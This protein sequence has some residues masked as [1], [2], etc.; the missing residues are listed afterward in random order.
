MRTENLA[1][2]FT[3]IKGYT[4]RTGKQTH[5]ETRVLLKLHANLVVPVIHGFDGRV[6]KA[7]G[8][9]FLVVFRSPTAAVLCGMTIQDVLHRHNHGRPPEQQIHLRV[10][11]NVGEVLVSRGDV[12]G[13]PVNIASRVEHITPANEVYLT[14]A[15]HLAM[16]KSEI[17]AESMGSF[18]LK[19]IRDAVK[20]FRVPPFASARKDG[21]VPEESQPGLGLP[22]RELSVPGVLMLPYGGTHLARL[23]AQVITPARRRLL[24]GGGA[25][26][27]MLLTLLLTLPPWIREREWNQLEALIGRG[28]TAQ[29][30]RALSNLEHSGESERVR[31]LNLQHH[32]GVRLVERDEGEPAVGLLAVMEPQ[33]PDE[34]SEFMKLQ[35]NIFEL[36]LRQGNTDSATRL[37]ELAA[38]RTTPDDKMLV[39]ER[40]QLAQALLQR[41]RLQ[42]LAVVLKSI[43]ATSPRDPR[44]SVLNGHMLVALSAREDRGNNL[45][46]GLASYREALTVEL[47]AGDDP[48]LV[49]N[50]AA[51]YNNGAPQR[52]AEARGVADAIVDRYLRTRAMDALVKQ[53]DQPNNSKE[54]RDK[55][56]LR[57]QQL[58]G[59][60]E[61]D[62]VRLML[63]DLEAARCS[64]NSE[65]AGS[66]RLIERLRDDGGRDPR[67]IGALV[68]LAQRHDQCEDSA[69]DA[70]HRLVG[71]RVGFLSADDVKVRELLARVRN[72][73]CKKADAA[74]TEEALAELVRMG[75]A[76]AVGPILKLGA[77]RTE[78]AE[79]VQKSAE[80]LV[81][82]RV[83]YESAHETRFRELMAQ[84][85]AGSCTGKAD[86]AAL[87]DT[88]RALARLGDRRAAGEL[89]GVARRGNACSDSALTAVRTLLKDDNVTLSCVHPAM[90]ELRNRKCAAKK[91]IPLIQ[92]SVDTLVADGD[93]KS[94]GELLT[95]AAKKNP[96]AEVYLQGA[97]TL[98]RMEGLTTA[99]RAAAE[100]PTTTTA[101]EKVP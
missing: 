40:V 79:A 68:A 89:L 34:R 39:E 21:V 59:E 7:I 1:I 95:L 96:C 30:L 23:E 74:Q 54:A 81:G 38:T 73:Q 66:R 60:K 46:K 51:A 11:I 33:T 10:A 53:L 3:D 70:V 76:R 32:L 8:D 22:S 85:R 19:G 65:A 86:N 80:S 25:A 84:L 42:E 50:V 77:E 41:G 52:S 36:L 47:A 15:V 87:L 28:E 18:E 44:A 67:V 90:Y 5:A 48:L 13:E 31:F 83:V 62:R 2:M 14:E 88:V 61:V 92:K 45:I 94:A 29:A 6:V 93:L 17:R 49:T 69:L 91:D 63:Q 26:L 43:T 9:A 99:C 24:I 58:G 64:T 75:D 56:A 101:A 16:N 98:T 57:I 27:G 97:R 82:K 37:L 72:A 12:F 71:E 78:C 35:K 100:A 20:V 4:E 55:L